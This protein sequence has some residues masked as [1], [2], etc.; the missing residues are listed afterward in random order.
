MVPLYK[1]RLPGTEMQPFLGRRGQ[2][3]CTCSQLPL[4]WEVDRG[5]GA[6]GTAAERLHLQGLT[7]PAGGCAALNSRPGGY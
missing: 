4:G 1:V 5:S 6:D 2:W 3:F 7:S